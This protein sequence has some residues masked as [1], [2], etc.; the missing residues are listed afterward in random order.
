VIILKAMLGL[1]DHSLPAGSEFTS[2]RWLFNHQA[3]TL[4]PVER[5]SCKICG[6]KLKQIKN[7]LLSYSVMVLIIILWYNII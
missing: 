6:S 2:L 7:M 5:R 4:D 3:V 1:K